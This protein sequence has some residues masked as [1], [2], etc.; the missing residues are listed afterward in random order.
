M[1]LTAKKYKKI[2]NYFREK[3]YRIKLFKFVYKL[4]PVIV[5]SVYGIIII[6]LIWLKDCRIIKVIEVPAVVF[7]GVTILRRLFNLPRPYEEMDIR[8]IISKNKSGHS[9]PSRHVVSAV[10]IAMACLYVNV[11]LGIA[12][13]VISM[14]IAILRPIAGVHYV[15]D[16]AAGFLISILSGLIGFYL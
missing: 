4:M 5:F 10:I 8:P 11:A 13:L 9:F 2:E 16:V 15:R 6:S 12:M 7:A 1:E 14:I 3:Q